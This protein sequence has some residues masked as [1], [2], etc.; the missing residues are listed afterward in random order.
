MRFNTLAPIAK[1]E[2]CCCFCPPICSIAWSSK[3]MCFEIDPVPWR[4]DVY[5][6]APKLNEFHINILILLTHAL[7]LLCE[8]LDSLLSIASMASLPFSYFQQFLLCTICARY[9]RVF[10][11]SFLF[12]SS[13][14]AHLNRWICRF[15]LIQMET[16][17]FN[18]CNWHNRRV[19]TNIVLRDIFSAFTFYAALQSNYAK[20]KIQN[21]K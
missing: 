1:C 2:V 3:Q 4:Y 19:D 8:V 18:E 13:Y 15:E 11:V 7:S 9:V 10:P 14:S 20:K 5:E 17:E 21:I 16:Y 12:Q 6:I